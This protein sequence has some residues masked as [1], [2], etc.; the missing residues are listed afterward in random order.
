MVFERLER[1]YFDMGQF[2]E[3]LTFYRE[4]LHRTPREQSVPALLALAEIHRRKGDLDPAE[5]FVREALEIDPEALRAHRFGIKIAL[6]RGDLEEATVR[7]DHLLKAMDGAEF[8][9]PRPP[10]SPVD[11]DGEAGA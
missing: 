2:A 4:L 7:L 10:R 8:S 11:P 3:V 9:G 1:T 5:A 6:D